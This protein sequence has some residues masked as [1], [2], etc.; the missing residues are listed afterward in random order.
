MSKLTSISALYHVYLSLLGS[1]CLYGNLMNSNCR[2]FLALIGQTSHLVARPN[3]GR[4]HSFTTGKVPRVVA[5]NKR[6]LRLMRELPQGTSALTCWGNCETSRLFK[7]QFQFSIQT[8]RLGADASSDKKE[9][10]G[11]GGGGHSVGHS[12]SIHVG[13]FR[14]LMQILE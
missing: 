6:M 11:G 2:S 5:S 9:V 13:S 8:S 14:W 1:W 4:A 3:I 12:I 10:S 7:L